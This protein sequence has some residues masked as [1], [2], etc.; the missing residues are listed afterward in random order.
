MRC[1]AY[2]F[3]LFSLS[4]ERG[5]YGKM[6]PSFCGDSLYDRLA[7]LKGVTMANF[8]GFLELVLKRRKICDF[9]FPPPSFLVFLKGVTMAFFPGFSE[10]VFERRKLSKK[11]RLGWSSG[12]TGVDFHCLLASFGRSYFFEFDSRKFLPINR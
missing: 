11:I 12:R 10:L 2:I 9:C 5:H 3:P 4:F 8:P 6:F 7:L 1:G